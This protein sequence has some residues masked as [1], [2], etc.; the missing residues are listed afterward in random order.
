M[1][2]VGQNLPMEIAQ[3]SF[4]GEGRIIVEQGFN[5]AS[6]FP[7]SAQLCERRRS[8]RECLQMIG[9]RIQGFPRPGQRRVIL[10]EQVMAERVQGRPLISGIAIV[11]LRSH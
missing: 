7:G 9:I 10:P 6:R 1:R 3:V 8:H 2:D 5:R 11:A 4:D